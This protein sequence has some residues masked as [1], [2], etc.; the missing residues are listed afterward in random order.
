M[1]LDIFEARDLA[2]AEAYWD[3]YVYAR[4]NDLFL[5]YVIINPRVDR[6]KAAIELGND[7]PMM[8]IVDEDAA[9]RHCTRRQDARHQLD[10]GERGLRRAFAAAASG[11]G[12]LRHQLRDPNGDKGSQGPLAKIL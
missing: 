11:R 10:H 2:R 5:T 1:G 9:R 12:R 4:D 7:D 6:S 3:C 8:K